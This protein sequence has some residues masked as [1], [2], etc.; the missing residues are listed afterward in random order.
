MFIPTPQ[1]LI[2]VLFKN[3]KSV[4]CA[5]FNLSLRE[6]EAGQPDLYSDFQDSQDYLR[7]SVLGLGI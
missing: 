2:S 7:N 4:P 3:V 5:T 1:N 6:A